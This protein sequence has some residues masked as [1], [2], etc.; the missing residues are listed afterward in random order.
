MLDRG[1]PDPIRIHTAEVNGV[2]KPSRETPA[3]NRPDHYPLLRGSSQC[4][5][6]SLKFVDALSPKAGSTAKLGADGVIQEEEV[7]DG[8]Q[9]EM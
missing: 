4:Q 9:T 1:D 6:L 8:P 3:N 7:A 2:R 5:Y